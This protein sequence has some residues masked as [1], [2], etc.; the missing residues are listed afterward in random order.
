[1]GQNKIELTA[2]KHLYSDL[3]NTEAI[4]ESRGS[5]STPLIL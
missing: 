2:E 4:I 3:K 1:M 5:T